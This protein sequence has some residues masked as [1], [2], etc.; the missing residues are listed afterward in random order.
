[1]RTE[2]HINLPSL[3]D[4]NIFVYLT[5]FHSTSLKFTYTIIVTYLHTSNYISEHLILS[6]TYNKRN[7]YITIN[8]LVLTNEQ[9]KVCINLNEMVNDASL[10]A[11]QLLPYIQTA[12][13]TP[14]L[15]HRYLFLQH[16]VI[17]CLV[18]LTVPHNLP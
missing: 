5:Y 10:S 17:S 11:L 4:C 12:A 9:Q 13:I 7:L 16:T 6:V 14:L 8:L 3:V 15:V 2:S 18:L 1:M